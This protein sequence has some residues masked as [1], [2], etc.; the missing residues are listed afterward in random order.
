MPAKDQ[1]I[2]K[3]VR[4]SEIDDYLAEEL[5]KA[6]Y[7]K[8]DIQK[9]ALGTRVIIYA[10][11][12]GLVIGKRGRTV[13]D[14]TEALETRFGLENPQ[15]EVNEIETPELSARV[16]ASRLASALERGI[17]FRRA[18][19]SIMRRVM[20]AGAKG[21]EIKISGKLTSQRAKYQ[22]FRDGFVSKT[23]EPAVQF[24]DDAV[25]HSLSKPGITGVHVK[26]MLPHAHLPDDIEILEPESQDVSL[27]EEKEGGEKEEA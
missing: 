17:H 1:F 27:K 8:V 25:V 13:R 18:A 23:G 15:I 20:A 2:E 5:K 3:G 12:P 19:Y 7:E 6:G 4:R 16:M 14:L 10:A 21:V 24:V 11:R 22:K 9:T 26:I